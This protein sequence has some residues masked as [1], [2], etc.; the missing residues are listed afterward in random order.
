MLPAGGPP[1]IVIALEDW[2]DTAA[3]GPDETGG[4]MPALA[5]CPGNP[6][7][8]IYTSGSTGRPKGVVIT[9]GSVVNHM[10][11][12]Q[13]TYRLN[14]S[15]RVLQ[16]TPFGFDASVWE[17]FW[18]LLEGAILVIA[19]PGGHQDPRYLAGLIRR[20]QVTIAQFV[21][22]ML[23]LFVQEPAAAS[24]T[25][26][27]AVFSGGEAIPADLYDRFARLFAVPLRNLYGPAEATI[28]VTAWQSRTGTGV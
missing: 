14:A 1:R 25:G 12:M 7:Y 5:A 11:W 18:P 21:P 27:R 6:A 24:C 23:E 17:F 3:G 19:R 8:V 13:D 28:D 15:D 20:E 9:H 4:T 16:K 22:A 10:A 2:Q 26:M